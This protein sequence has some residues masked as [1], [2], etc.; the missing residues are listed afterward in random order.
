MRIFIVLSE[1][2][3]KVRKITVYYRLPFINIVSISRVL[4][5]KRFEKRPKNWYQKRAVL[6]KTNQN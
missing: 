4:K 3:L 6:A 2:P 5:V 1:S